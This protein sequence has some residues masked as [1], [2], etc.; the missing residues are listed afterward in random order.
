MRS[1]NIPDG[2]D[3]RPQRSRGAERGSESR[4][5][6]NKQTIPSSASTA[7]ASTLVRT[8][9][10]YDVDC[11]RRHACQDRK[12]ETKRKLNSHESEQKDGELDRKH[13]FLG[14]SYCL[15]RLWLKKS[16]KSIKLKMKGPM[17]QKSGRL[18]TPPHLAHC[19]F[20]L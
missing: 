2:K 13:S 16:R 6:V 1:G 20:T 17:G 12:E 18:S 15:Y 10:S 4:S 14:L 5:R 19:K 9:G 8:V 11:L 3:V 7:M